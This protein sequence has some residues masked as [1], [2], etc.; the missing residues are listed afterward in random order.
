MYN[1]IQIAHLI[2]VNY[3][4]LIDWNDRF[5]YCPECHEPVYEDE[6]EDFDLIDGNNNF[7]C[8]ICESILN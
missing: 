8:P 4:S 3:D 5:F 6:W 2:E 7:I 1:W